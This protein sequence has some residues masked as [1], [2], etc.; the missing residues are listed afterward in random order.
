MK[1]VTF[2]LRSPIGSFER[3]GAL[4][5]ERVVDL[6]LAYAD[7]LAR[8]ERDPRAYDLATSRIPPHMIEFF[9]GGEPSK[10]AAK[11]GLAHVAERLEKE[12]EVRG[13][14]GE[15]IIYER[16]QVRLLAP[17]PRPNSVRDTLSFELH[18]K[19]SLGKLGLEVPPLWYEI[20]SYYRSSPDIVIGPDEPIL[21]PSFTEQLDY[22]LE[23]GIYIGKE[24]RDIPREKAEEYI[25]GYTIFNDVSARD[26]QSREMTLMLG[27][28]KGK[29]F[30]HGNVMGPCLVTP[31][32]IDPYNLKMVARV[33][34]EAWSEGNSGAMYHRFPF[35]IEYISRDETLYP[36]DFIGSGTVGFGCGLELDRWIKPGDIIELEVEGIGVLR[37]PV[38]R[39]GLRDRL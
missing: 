9:I 15:V 39:R 29:N 4:L 21:W 8:V 36:G 22:E 24:G 13:P 38:E 30:D 35:L 3:I 20:P 12:P 19:N 28:C 37:N 34:G 32:E 17:V 18:L 23:F 14:E 5:G 26:I 10:K 11:R 7:Y 16:S 25:A 33:N 6:N 1:L 2:E 27:P 31:D